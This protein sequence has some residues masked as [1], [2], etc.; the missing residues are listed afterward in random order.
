MI[1]KRKTKR[2]SHILQDDRERNYSYPTVLRKINILTAY[3]EHKIQIQE[4]L[5]NASAVR[6]RKIHSILSKNNI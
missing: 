2:G 5:I 6:L 4:V 3:L 1:G